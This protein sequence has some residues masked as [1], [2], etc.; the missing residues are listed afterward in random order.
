MSVVLRTSEHV[1]IPHKKFKFPGGE[2]Q[3]QTDIDFCRDHNVYI[4]CRWENSDDLIEIMLIDNAIYPKCPDIFIPYFPYARQDRR[5]NKGEADSF[6]V[7]QNILGYPHRVS[8]VDIHNPNKF[9]GNN[10]STHKFV[11]ELI[12]EESYDF[13]VCPDKGAVSRF[14][15]LN[16]PTLY[17]EKT[18]DPATGKIIDFT[19]NYERSLHG[20]KLLVYD[21][22]CD[23][24]ATFKI[25][26]DSLSKN[27][28]IE[29]HL[30]V[31]HGIFSKGNEPL[32]KYQKIFTTD[33]IKQNKLTPTK[34]FNVLPYEN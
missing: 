27:A 30:F 17:C 6:E 25:L 34:I 19:M 8:S 23:G 12:E 22:I 21:D 26:A 18:R 3:I 32:E 20:T 7:I 2:M 24:G 28:S 15:G 9:R 11:H 29:F 13:L 4:D 16:Y 5:C 1:I 31:S 10:I 33:S 14:Q